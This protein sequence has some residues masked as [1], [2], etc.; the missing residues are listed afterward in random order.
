MTLQSSINYKHNRFNPEV[1]LVG[2]RDEEEEWR[3]RFTWPEEDRHTV[4]CQP[5]RPGEF[6]WFRSANV[7][8][9]ERYRPPRKTG[10]DNG[11]G[12]R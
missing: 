5:W 3:R 9:I 11:G 4:T 10:T 7:V 6:R 1:G 8:P 2:S 12:Q